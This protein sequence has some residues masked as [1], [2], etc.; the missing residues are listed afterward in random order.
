VENRR[1]ALAARAQGV[2]RSESVFVACGWGADAAD[3][4]VAVQPDQV[5]VAVDAGRKPADTARWVGAVAAAVRIDAVAT[6]GSATT[7]TPETVEE[8]GLPI[9]WIDDR[10]ATSRAA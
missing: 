3:V 10:P 1:D 5:W 9:G 8:L 2:E 4:L 7:S 6:V